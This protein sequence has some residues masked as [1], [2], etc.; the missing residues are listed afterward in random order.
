MFVDILSFFIYLLSTFMLV[1]SIVYIAKYRDF[2]G[3]KITNSVNV[4]VIGLLFLIIYTF[5]FL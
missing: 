1:I 2:V 4:A 5:S 3:E